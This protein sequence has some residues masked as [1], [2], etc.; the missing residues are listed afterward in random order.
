MKSSGEKYQARA[1]PLGMQVRGSSRVFQF[2]TVLQVKTLDPGTHAYS[3]W[4]GVPPEGKCAFG[5]LFYRS[6]SMKVTCLDSFSNSWSSKP[7][8][9]L[10]SSIGLNSAGAYLFQCAKSCL[11]KC[12]SCSK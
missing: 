10:A 6:S 2:A 8:K 5:R 9:G 12:Y 3:F 4:E 11:V 1:L 7:A